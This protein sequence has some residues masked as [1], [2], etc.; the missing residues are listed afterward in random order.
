MSTIVLQNIY[1]EYI[2]DKATTYALKNV[3]FSAEEGEMIAIMGPS[4]AG[5]TTLLN[6]LGCLD[7]QSKGNYYLDGRNIKDFTKKQLA[8]IRNE[9]FGFVFQ[10]FA[11]IQEYTVFENLELPI[12][13]GNCFKS[14]EKRIRKKA[15]LEIIGKSLENVGLSGHIHKKPSQLSGG[16]QQRVAIARALIAN[17]G[18]I[19]A[20][21][22][23]GA[24]DQKTGRKIMDLLKNINKQGK[25]IIIVTHDLNVASYCER[26]VN[27]IDG[28]ITKIKDKT[29]ESCNE[30]KL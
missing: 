23:T 17:P 14:F 24:L 29:I 9:K 13:Y 5:K 16:Q 6:I 19:L 21:E 20:D 3:S 26:V 1:K 7:K 22:P 18:I 25:T 30:L 8:E 28:E 10:Q 4:G 15:R 2:Y 12:L 11:L 27:V